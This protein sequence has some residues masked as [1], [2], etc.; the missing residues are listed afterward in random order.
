MRMQAA[1]LYEQG[2][3]APFVDSA[4]F[5][6][7]EVELEGPGEGEVLI[8][9]RAAGLCHSDL[10]TVEGKRPRQLPIV[11]GHEGAGV[12][13]EVGRGV[14][15]LRPGDHVVLTAAGG[16]GHCDRCG[17][18]RPVLC[19]Q[20]PRIRLQ[21]V[22]ANGAR[23]LNVRGRPAYHYSGV[24]S[25]AQYAVATPHSV[26]CIERHYPLDVAAMFGC[27]VLTGAGAVLNAARAKAGQSVAVVGLGG[28][29]LNAVMAASAVGC[30]PI[31]GI[32]VNADKLAL[33]RELGCTHTFLAED[34]TMLEAVRD[35]TGGGVDVAVEVSGTQGGVSAA[36]D[37]TR[38][39]G[40]IVCI[41]IASYGTRY[42]YPHTAIVGDEKVVRGSLLGSGQPQR[43]IPR[44]LEM[45]G[46]GQL[47]VD[48]LISSTMP[49]ESLNLAL[50]QLK[51]GHALRQ[52]LLPN[53][54]N[55]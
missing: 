44:Y 5:V 14:T 45:F 22:L 51:S 25:F 48:R 35:V 9:I 12:V 15:Q 1:V 28:V 6:M 50:D 3:Q 21:G 23:R 33:A 24:S 11:G 42:E 8:E 38:R 39:G 30:G 4:P 16:C 34:A 10:S 52:I 18:G 54:R 19:E 41:G 53:G 31:I 47:P 2:R 46:A 29:G 27:A 20:I 32:D 13:V 55:G 17:K 37:M 7:E 49:L 26:I 40:E 43:D 36:V